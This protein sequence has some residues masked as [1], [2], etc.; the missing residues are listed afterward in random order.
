MPTTERPAFL[1]SYARHDRF[2]AVIRRAYVRGEDLP[3]LDILDAFFLHLR[4]RVSRLTGREYESCGYKD[5]RDIN[6]GDDWAAMLSRACSTSN[7]LVSV[8]SRGYF[9]SHYCGRE[10][11][12][13]RSRHAL[14]PSA[15]VARGPFRLIPVFW[16]SPRECWP[17]EQNQGTSILKACQYE[18]NDLP[19]EY[20][21]SGLLSTIL[22]GPRDDDSRNEYISKIANIFALRIKRLCE[23]YTLLPTSQDIADIRRV[24]PDFGKEQEPISAKIASTIPIDQEIPLLNSPG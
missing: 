17:R 23:D 18:S 13:I 11:S 3:D 5:S 7:V 19:N 10:F 14:L 8:L 2:G 4:D 16:E 15:H 20:V 24:T 9:E 1:F 21:R 12:I 22:Q 6:L